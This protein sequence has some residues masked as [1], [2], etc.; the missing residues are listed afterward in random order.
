M[1]GQYM[2]VAEGQ[3]AVIA[4]VKGR[5]CDL[6]M[7]E[8]TALNVLARAS[9]IATRAHRLVVLKCKKDWKGVVAGTRKVG[10]PTRL[11]VGLCSKEYCT[12]RITSNMS[13]F[14]KLLI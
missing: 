4:T 10:V 14:S 1:V 6:L 8:R 2:K 7:G 13:L 5:V 3:R 9:G 12:M 11:D